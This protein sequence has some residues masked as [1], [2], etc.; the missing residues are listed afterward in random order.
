VDAVV[1]FGALPA[2]AL[3]VSAGGAV[4]FGEWTAGVFGSFFPAQALQGADSTDVEFGLMTAELRTCRWL[5]HGFASVRPCLGF[6]LG[7]LSA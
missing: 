7:Q 1:D 4:Q 5:F 6:E 3:G 2:P